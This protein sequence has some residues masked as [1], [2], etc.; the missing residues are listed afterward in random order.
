[1]ATR[2][3]WAWAAGLFDGEGC[4]G[5]KTQWTLQ[6]VVGQ[7]DREVLDRFRRITGNAGKVYGPY[8]KPGKRRPY[9]VFY[10]NK[11]QEIEHIARRMWPWLGRIKRAQFTAVEISHD[12]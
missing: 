9:Y 5:R 1:M 8:V 3:E 6:L 2:T 7:A 10:V 12:T 4:V 11:R